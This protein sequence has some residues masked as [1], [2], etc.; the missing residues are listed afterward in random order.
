[1]NLY[2]KCGDFNVSIV[3]CNKPA[4]RVYGAFVWQS[5]LFPLQELYSTKQPAKYILDIVDVF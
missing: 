5:I 1:M 2:D 4:P 3:N